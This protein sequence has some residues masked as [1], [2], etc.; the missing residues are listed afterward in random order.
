MCIIGV[1]C[2]LTYGPHGNYADSS[3]QDRAAIG[4]CDFNLSQAQWMENL[5]QQL[6]RAKAQQGMFVA[7]LWCSTWF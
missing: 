1:P 6:A 3:V 7:S 2:T 4:S 5:K